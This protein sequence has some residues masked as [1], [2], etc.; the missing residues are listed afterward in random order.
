[1]E[2]RRFLSLAGV[3]A[4]AALP[5]RAHAQVT[6]ADWSGAGEPSGR[7]PIDTSALTDEERVHVP[8]LRLPSRVRTGRAFDLVVQIGVRPHE[9]TA[10]HRI[11]WVEISLGERRVFVADL[12][13]D[14][15]YP[16]V[17]VPLILHEPATLTARARCTLHGV[18][19]TRRDLTPT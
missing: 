3:T 10:E 7:E 1:M 15:P 9:C 8:V 11:D 12:S 5:G 16:V 2:R 17:R 13:A 14:V 19:R 4:V 18:W 6:R